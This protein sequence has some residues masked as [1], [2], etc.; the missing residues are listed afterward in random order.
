MK[1]KIGDN[2]VVVKDGEHKWFLGE[3]LENDTENK[4]YKVQMLFGVIYLDE[5]E[6]R[7]CKTYDLKGGL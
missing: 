6:L 5:Y 1:F 4:D 2:V 3:I 7:A